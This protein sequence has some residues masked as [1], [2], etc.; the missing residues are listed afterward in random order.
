MLLSVVSERSRTFGALDASASALASAPLLGRSEFLLRRATRRRLPRAVLRRPRMSR[1]SRMSPRSRLR[2]SRLLT[3]YSV[4]GATAAGNVAHGMPVPSNRPRVF[5]SSTIYDFA[6]LRS[7]IKFWLEDLDYEVDASEFND[8][9]K[10]VAKNSYDA[11]LKA[12]NRANYFVL[13]IGSRAGGWYDKPSKTTITRM[14]YQHA[15]ERAKRGEL[16][17]LAFVR[18]G[19]WDVREDR[20][21]LARLLKKDYASENGLTEEEIENITHHQSRV[22]VDADAIFAFLAEVGRNAEM[23]TAVGGQGPLPRANW[24]HQFVGF[25]EIIDSLRIDLGGALGL[26]RV[27]LTA[28]LRHEL[29]E[30]LRHLLERLPSDGTIEPSYSGAA[31]ARAQ[32]SGGPM[33][34]SK[35]KGRRLMWLSMFALTGANSGG[36]LGTQFV[37]EAMVSGEFLDFDKASDAYVV[38]PIQGAMITLREE[39]RRL[40]QQ[41]DAL[42]VDDRRSLV[43]D[44]RDLKDA[45]HLVEID[46]RRLVAIMS[47]HDRQANIV[48]LSASILRAI[49]GDLKL[50]SGT[51]VWPQTPFAEEATQIERETPASTDVEAWVS[52][53]KP[54]K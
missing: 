38:G 16:K 52:A 20:G 33:A 37:D 8:F 6:D 23:K 40:R 4:S 3:T 13:L 15:Y 26:R 18:R 54:Q 31:H 12:I 50:L 34:T 9:D 44:F 22:V 25:R 39:I 48:A 29:V 1:Q 43:E 35:I 24:I 45:D 17:L 14:E 30:N 10:D 28:N 49:G 2:R 46:N 19:V 42:G 47:I 7:A 21:G 51:R 41:E 5:L 53:L 32:F 11:C 27:A 36:R